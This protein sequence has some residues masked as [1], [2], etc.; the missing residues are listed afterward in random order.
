M[1]KEGCKKQGFQCHG[2]IREILK[3]LWTWNQ[4]ASLPGLALPLISCEALGKLTH[5]SG[6]LVSPVSHGESAAGLSSQDFCEAETR[7]QE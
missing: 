2:W 4:E 6:P 7:E 1:N 3:E 5:V